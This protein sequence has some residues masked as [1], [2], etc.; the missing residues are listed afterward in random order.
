MRLA[1]NTRRKI[2]PKKRH[3][4]TIAQICRAVSSQLRYISTIGKKC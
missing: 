4:G 2:S 3:L 1:E